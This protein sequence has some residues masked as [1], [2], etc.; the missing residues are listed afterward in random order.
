[1]PPARRARIRSSSRSTA[2]RPGVILQTLA[3]LAVLL[4]LV[5]MIF[6]PGA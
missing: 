4:I 1:M 3:S 5:D 2:R 6:K